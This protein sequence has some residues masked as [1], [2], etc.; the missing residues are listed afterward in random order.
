MLE[1][2]LSS[3]KTNYKNIYT[4]VLPA[5]LDFH[6]HLVL[7]WV[8]SF[9]ESN[10][11]LITND[12][13]WIQKALVVLCFEIEKE[14]TQ[15]TL[16]RLALTHTHW[17]DLLIYFCFDSTNVRIHLY[18]HP[19]LYSWM[20]ISLYTIINNRRV[21]AWFS[22]QKD[23]ADCTPAVSF[24]IQHIWFKIDKEK[25]KKAHLQWMIK[26]THYSPL[27]QQQTSISFRPVSICILI[28]ASKDNE[29]FTP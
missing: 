24:N 10:S 7:K 21:Y 17:T 12:F 13:E 3:K 25:T 28:T 16:K 27:Q 11:I 14:K 2:A 22:H 29:L 18:F 4:P 8:C 23:S 26:F 15:N 19:L 5:E 9:P 6:T 20:Y 1:L